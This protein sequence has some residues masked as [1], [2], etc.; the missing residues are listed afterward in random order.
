MAIFS[1]RK[2]LFQ[3]NLLLARALVVQHDTLAVHIKLANECRRATV[4]PEVS[5]LGIGMTMHDK[6]GRHP[7]L[8]FYVHVLVVDDV[9]IT[10]IYAATVWVLG[11]F[12]RA[13]PT[14]RAEIIGYHPHRPVA[15]VNKLA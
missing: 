3:Q 4:D 14:L 12:Q 11:I 7:I 1:Q 5:S 2:R 6:G 13:I 15:I 9:V 10:V 8:K